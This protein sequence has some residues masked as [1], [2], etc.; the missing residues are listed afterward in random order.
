MRPVVTPERFPV[1]LVWS[2][3]L[4]R[5]P[6]NLWLRTLLMD[7]YEALQTKANAQVEAQLV[8]LGEGST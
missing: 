6:G 1:R 2:S 7:T 8:D 3:R 5:D 4:S